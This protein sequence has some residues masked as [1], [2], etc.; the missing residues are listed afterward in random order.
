MLTNQKTTQILGSASMLM[1]EEQHDLDKLYRFLL[2]LNEAFT[3]DNT[4]S[5]KSNKMEKG[6][7]TKQY[8]VPILYPVVY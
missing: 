1:V 5:K 8:D 7:A 3:Q 6:E 2:S 4:T